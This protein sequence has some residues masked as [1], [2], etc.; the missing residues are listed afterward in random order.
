MVFK[1]ESLY[2]EL[3]DIP[4]INYTGATSIGCFPPAAMNEYK[5]PNLMI[6]SLLAKR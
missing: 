1:I 5:D 6:F 2:N 3:V 4:G